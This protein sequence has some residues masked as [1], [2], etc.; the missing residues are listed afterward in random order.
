MVE[1]A[2]IRQA[3]SSG[4]DIAHDL[5]AEL[6]GDSKME[7]SHHRCL[8]CRCNTL[9][10]PDGEELE[11]RTAAEVHHERDEVLSADKGD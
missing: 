6:G 8:L 5:R 2:R 10:R 11:A 4:G 7:V 9:Q 3:I 1:E